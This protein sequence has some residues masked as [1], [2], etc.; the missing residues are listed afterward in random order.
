MTE[1]VEIKNKVKAK[2]GERRF[3][4]TLSVAAEAV[5]LAEKWGENADNAYLAA[6]VHDYA[7]EIPIAEATQMLA[8]FGEDIENEYIFCPALI[9][10]PLAAHIAKIELGIENKDV[11]NAVR[12]HTS[13]RCGMSRLEKIIYLA[14][15]IEPLRKFEGVD[16]ARR[17]AYES[18]DRAVLC[19]A[20]MVIDFTIKR[21][22]F[23]HIGTTEMRNELLIKT[24]E[25]ENN[26]G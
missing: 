13:G 8:D 1:L 23:L 15:F 17:L 24:K 20:E 16:A 25:E 6:L 3:L 9:H 10:G 7:K 18:L 19:E 4:H 22:Q 21:K 11:L 2:L 26:E 5:R 14:D 12:Y